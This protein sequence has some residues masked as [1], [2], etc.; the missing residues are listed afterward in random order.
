MLVCL[1]VNSVHQVLKRAD[2]HF[3]VKYALQILKI[4]LFCKH[5]VKFRFV[6]FPVQCLCN[7]SLVCLIG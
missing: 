7:C 6:C 2:V 5:G 1:V 4:D 3:I